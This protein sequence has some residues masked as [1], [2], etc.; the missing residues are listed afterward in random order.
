VST[1]IHLVRC[2]TDL[3]ITYSEGDIT[4]LDPITEM[5]DVQTELILSDLEICSKKRSKHKNTKAEEE[6]W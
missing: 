3:E 1:I 5:E 2:F 6:V 4:N